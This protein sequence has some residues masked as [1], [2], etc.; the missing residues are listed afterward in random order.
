[1]AKEQK[2]EMCQEGK[3]RRNWNASLPAHRWEFTCTGKDDNRL[4]KDHF[5]SWHII[6]LVCPIH[7]DALENGTLT[8][9]HLHSFSLSHLT[10]HTLHHLAPDITPISSFLSPIFALSLFFFSHCLELVKDLRRCFS[11]VLFGVFDRFLHAIHEWNEWCK[12][13]ISR[14]SPSPTRRPSVRA[15]EIALR[16]RRERGKIVDKLNK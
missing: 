4:E 2:G 10:F 9:S 7:G 14:V 3:R 5:L 13:T 12:E 1:M 8:S 11:V 16:S 6:V 15:S